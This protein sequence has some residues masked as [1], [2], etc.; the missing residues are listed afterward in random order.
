M[1]ECLHAAAHQTLRDIEI[2]CIDDGSADGS[3]KILNAYAARD[4]RI[5]VLH[6]PHIGAG[7]ARNI[8]IDK[9][10]G[11]YLTFWDSDD[12]VDLN[13]LE[14]MYLKARRT[15]ADIVQ[16]Q[17]N[18]L[19]NE[20]GVIAPC[21][22]STN[23]KLLPEKEVF[24]RRDLEQ[25][26]FKFSSG[27]AWDKLFK[28]DFI[29]RKK[30]RFQEI[31]NCNDTAFSFSSLALADRITVVLK[32]FVTYRMNRTSSLVDRR[33]HHW[34][35][36]YAALKHIQKTLQEHHVYDQLHTAFDNIA[37][38]FSV[39]VLETLKEPIRSIGYEAFFRRMLPDL[40]DAIPLNH[41][42]E[43]R[44]KKRLCLTPVL[45]QF[46]AKKMAKIIPVVFSARAGEVPF[47]GVAIRSLM[48]YA[49]PGY[50][51]DIYIL[52]QNI[53]DTDAARLEGL[54]SRQMRVC[55][56]NVSP[57]LAEKKEVVGANFFSVIPRV[58][59][60]YQRV[61]CLTPFSII[62]TDLRD[63]LRTDLQGRAVAGVLACLKSEEKKE[64]A[65]KRLNPQ[66][67]ISPDLILVDVDKLSDAD[68]VQPS[69]INMKWAGEI[70][71][72]DARCCV[73]A[74][75]LTAEAEEYDMH[76]LDAWRRTYAEAQ[77]LTLSVKQ[78]H[79]Y[80]PISALWRRYAQNTI[81]FEELIYKKVCKQL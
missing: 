20:T 8:G 63:I 12:Y 71:V 38:G 73:S 68:A 29:R 78:L 34:D 69:D 21:S 26:I 62:Q 1:E 19:D 81:F 70:T 47:A 64:I 52:H 35:C 53:S 42:R 13:M 75:P 60:G 48:E 25:N 74:L 67:Y 49:A 77:V 15:D 36:F 33:E 6:T 66:S 44:R 11:A 28:A 43:I 24:S 79:Y 41:T 61:I 10:S 59:T 72:L 39:W 45:A 57:Y 65:K 40:V 50:F 14:D 46:Y 22:W 3:L 23:V 54:T 76:D 80:N 37:L 9:A 18:L 27:A 30:L 5:Q 17:A 58:L 56:V 32:P 16:C 55:C 2:I 31:T 7:G 4:S 51:Y